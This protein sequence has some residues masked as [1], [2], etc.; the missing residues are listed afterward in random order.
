MLSKFRWANRHSV[1]STRYP[2]TFESFPN[3]KSTWRPSSSVGGLSMSSSHV[4]EA[5]WQNLQK[6]RVTLWLSSQSNNRWMASPLPPPSSH[7][8]KGMVLTSTLVPFLPYSCWFIASVSLHIIFSGCRSVNLSFHWYDWLLTLP[9]LFFSPT[10]QSE[11]LSFLP[12]ISK[13]DISVSL[14]LPQILGLN[15]IMQRHEDETFGVDVH[16]CE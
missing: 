14:R 9:F 13:V 6:R 3:T 11:L 1:P 10:R 12:T 2:F 4:T 8:Q 7:D 15:H 5:F 16:H